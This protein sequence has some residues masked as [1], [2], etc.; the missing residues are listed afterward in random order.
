MQIQIDQSCATEVARFKTMVATWV[1][2]TLEVHLMVAGVSIEHVP[3]FLR[4]ATYHIKVTSHGLLS[5]FRLTSDTQNRWYIRCHRRHPNPRVKYH[6]SSTDEMR[7]I[8]GRRH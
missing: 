7:T 4:A 3:R 1:K 5:G 6:D 2:S 8:E